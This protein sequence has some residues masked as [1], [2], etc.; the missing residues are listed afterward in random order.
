MA[1]REPGA[2]PS[3][4]VNITRHEDLSKAKKDALEDVFLSFQKVSNRL[5]RRNCVNSIFPKF[6]A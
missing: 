3:S 1:W 5:P 2:E 6:L 4:T